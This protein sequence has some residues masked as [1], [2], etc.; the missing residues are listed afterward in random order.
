MPFT[1]SVRL[2][3]TLILVSSGRREPGT[4]KLREW[5]S[6]GLGRRGSWKHPEPNSGLPAEQAGDQRRRFL[7]FFLIIQCGKPLA[8][9]GMR[10]VD[11]EKLGI[12]GAYARREL[13]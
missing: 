12:N 7:T 13:H 3:N 8:S 9:L 4:L 5:R 11:F 2:M 10:A 1:S 6:W